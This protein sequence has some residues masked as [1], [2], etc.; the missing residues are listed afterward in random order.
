MT[1]KTILITGCSTGIG[2]A[3][4]TGLKARGYRVFATARKPS[5]IVRLESLGLEALALDYRDS[6][7]VQACAAEV[8]RR[9]D[10]KLFALFNNGAY[11]QPGAVE[12]ITRSVLEEQFAANVFGWHELTKACLPLLRA[13][14]EGRIVQCS[15][16]LGFLAL[17]WRGPYNA[18]KFALEGLTDT[19]RL[20][21]RGHPIKVI[22][23]NPG[24]IATDF[25]KNAQAAFD[26]NVDMSSSHYVT[27]FA[28]QRQRLAQGGSSR[29]KLPPEAVVAK[30]IVALEHPN[31]RPHYYVTLPTHVAALAR[32]FL[33][34]RWL[35]AFAARNS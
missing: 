2:L 14:G 12:D 32:R 19:L 35:D 6:T 28:A 17:K 11:G 9:T 1:S 3:A 27:E 4:A 15:S 25:V 33:P 18:S 13:N 23:I 7:S 5:D 24:P 20:E 10:G 22:T 31:P 8:A 16:V 26:R 29:F 34:G 21:L 30:L